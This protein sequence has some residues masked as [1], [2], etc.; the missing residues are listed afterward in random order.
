MS[1]LVKSLLNA[2]F[3][4]G[5]PVPK[6]DGLSFSPRHRLSAP[7][8]ANAIRRP[9]AGL[10]RRGIAL[11]KIASQTIQIHEPSV[12]AIHI[13]HLTQLA[14]PS[15]IARGQIVKLCGLLHCSHIWHGTAHANRFA[16]RSAPL[17]GIFKQAFDR[18]AES[19]RDML[20]RICIT[21]L[22]PA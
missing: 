19:L 16:H 3:F 7:Q 10:I 22:A 2:V 20:Y 9:G 8:A 17:F 18:N 4:G 11:F 6:R 1:Y 12:P 21:G 13:A 15:D 14:Q 5:C